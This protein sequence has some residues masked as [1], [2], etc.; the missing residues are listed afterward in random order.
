MAALLAFSVNRRILF[1]LLLICLLARPCVFSVPTGMDNRERNRVKQPV[2]PAFA[3]ASHATFVLVEGVNPRELWKIHIMPSYSVDITF[4]GG[5]SAGISL[6]FSVIVGFPFYGMHSLGGSMENPQMELDYSNSSNSTSCGVGL[7]LVPFAVSGTPSAGVSLNIG[8]IR[9][10]VALRFEV[11]AGFGP[12]SAAI[13]RWTPLRVFG[14]TAALI[15]INH[16]VSFELALVV[17]QSLTAIAETP[18]PSVV[19]RIGFF[20]RIA[21]FTALLSVSRDLWN[22]ANPASVS[23]GMTFVWETS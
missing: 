1:F 20:F 10:P 9:D 17:Q 7:S 15:V 11:N 16:M 21:P 23:T 22:P 6:P 8:F 3:L 13:G 5:L 14:S 2:I 18:A 12:L 4:A 19:G